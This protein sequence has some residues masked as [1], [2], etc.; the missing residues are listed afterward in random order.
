LFLERKLESHTFRFQKFNNTGQL[1]RPFGRSSV[2]SQYVLAIVLHLL[3][4]GF[5]PQAERTYKERS[6][7]G[8]EA[9]EIGQAEPDAAGVFT[10]MQGRRREPVT[11]RTLLTHCTQRATTCVAR[12]GHFNFI[13]NLERRQKAND[14]SSLATK[15]LPVERLP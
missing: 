5:P 1:F 3:R 14:L 8:R 13:A 7:A 11:W 4:F 9:A 2:V 15:R 10:S 12:S 6:R